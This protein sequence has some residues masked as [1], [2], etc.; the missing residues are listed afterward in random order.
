MRVGIHRP[1]PIGLVSLCGLIVGLLFSKCC[2]ARGAAGSPG[3]G[4]R[5]IDQSERSDIPRC[6]EPG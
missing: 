5:R 3:T 2:G 1:F 6:L 4:H